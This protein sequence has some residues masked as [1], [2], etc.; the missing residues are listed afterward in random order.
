[1]AAASDD[2]D[3]RRRLYRPG[4]SSADLDAYLD[5]APDAAE[6]DPAAGSR[7]APDATAPDEPGHDAPQR[8]Q[9]RRGA[10]AAVAIGALALVLGASALAVGRVAST[11]EP[12]PSATPSA[13]V[14]FTA[15]PPAPDDVLGGPAPADDGPRA[16]AR[17]TAATSG[18][19]VRYTT[20][21]GDTAPAVA[22]RFG[23][24]SA[25]VLAALPYGFD[26]A[27]LPGG[28]VLL[29]QRTGD[30]TAQRGASTC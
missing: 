24:C 6:P 11:T 27:R 3:L 20:R 29:L 13:V 18:S 7:P 19:S 25:D 17:G 5:V 15:A 16:G 14:R 22:S 28:Q 9:R 1:V 10:I 23:L 21:R 12:T 26:P 4:A 8:P 2:E 30:A